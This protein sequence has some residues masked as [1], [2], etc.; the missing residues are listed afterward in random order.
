MIKIN[1]KDSIIDI[2]IKIDNCKNKEI[3]LDF[4]FWH[5][6]IHNYISL[7]ILKAKAKKKNIIIITN[8]KTARKIGSKL[9]IKYSKIGDTD[10]LEYNYTKLEYTKYIIKRYFIELTQIFSDKTNNITF[11]YQKKYLLKNWK[12]WY[13]LI[14]LIS[15]VLLFFFIFYFAVN[16]TYIYITPEINIK[17]K[18]ENFIFKEVWSDELVDNNIIRLNKISKLIYLT[19]TFWTSWVNEKSLKRSKWTVTFFNELNEPVD[20]L[21]NTRLITKDWIIFRSDTSIRIPPSTY[22]ST[23]IIIPWKV[24]IP[25]T[26]TIK[27]INWKVVWNKSNIGDWIK[28]TIPWLKNNKDK[29]YAYTLWEIKW[30]NNKYVK[31]LTKDDLKNAENI[32]ETKLK[33]KALNELKK[34]ITDNNKKNNIIEELLWI[35]W[36]LQYSDFKIIWEK[37]LTIWEKLSEFELAWTIKIS[38]Y[39]YNTKKVLNQLST[40]IQSTLLKD[41]ETFLFINENSLRISNIIYKEKRPF[42]IKATAEVEAF[43]SHNFLTKKNNYTDKLKSIISWLPKEKA[44]KVL[45]NNSK[46]SDVYIEIRPFFIKTISKISDNI[47]IKVVNK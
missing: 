41:V 25:V 27:N 2:I 32:L 34:Q 6:I 21:Q 10:L 24:N 46:I 9:W 36:V 44:L 35:D 3:V 15:I 12:I 39:S 37:K 7:K 14:W 16:K 28:L 47:I 19:N 42:K 30:A 11:E 26:S 22:S 18:A 13:F 43:F 40:T 45:I 31:Q 29:I 33:Q 1:K 20:L 17:T 4:P 38:S 23:W 5:P 8:D